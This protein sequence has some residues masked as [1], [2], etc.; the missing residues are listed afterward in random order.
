MIENNEREKPKP[1]P[2]RGA[3]DLC[4]GMLNMFRRHQEHALEETLNRKSQSDTNGHS[5]EPHAHL[6]LERETTHN[7]KY[8]NERSKEGDAVAP[9]EY[10]IVLLER[11]SQHG[12]SGYTCLDM[13][14]KYATYVRLA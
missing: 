7:Q 13:A 9:Y 6:V 1:N 14:V 8:D 3:V 4:N 2:E 12:G 5:Q 11:M 10:E